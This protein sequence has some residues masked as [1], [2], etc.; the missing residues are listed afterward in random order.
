ML[1]SSNN[2]GQHG[3]FWILRRNIC[4]PGTTT[5][6]HKASPDTPKN[7]EPETSH[8]ETAAALIRKHNPER[9]GQRPRLSHFGGIIH[10]RL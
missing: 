2:G 3:Q 1:F 5:Q 8:H 7:Y 4:E 10:E 6:I 9:R